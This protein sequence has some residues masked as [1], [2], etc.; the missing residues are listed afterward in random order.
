[1]LHMVTKNSKLFE[2][3]SITITSK[4]I[5]RIVTISKRINNF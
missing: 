4:F 1:M 5:Y 2:R 3:I